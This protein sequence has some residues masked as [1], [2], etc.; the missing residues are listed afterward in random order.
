MRGS[1]EA[2]S[3]IA[4]RYT[5]RVVVSLLARGITLESA[6]DLAQETWIRLIQRQREGRLQEMRLP[7]LAIAQAAWLARESQRTQRRHEA[8][9]GSPRVPGEGVEG[10]ELPSGE[11]GPEQLVIDRQR[12]AIVTG[13]LMRCSPR[14]RQVFSAVYG[15]GGVSHAEIARQLGLSVQRVRQ[16]VCEVRAQMRR[17]LERREE[18]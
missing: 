7:G 15:S 3:E 9:L 11:A 14:S 8:L 17:A 16:I 6:E 10:D 2:W 12:L 5:H 4:R 18:P 1:D 13:E